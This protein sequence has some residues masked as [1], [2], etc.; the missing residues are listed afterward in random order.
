LTES[1]ELR[2]AAR[3]SKPQFR[4]G[5]VTIRWDFHTDINTPARRGEGGQGGKQ[6]DER[7]P[8]QVVSSQEW[9]KC[10]EDFVRLFGEIKSTRIPKAKLP[11]HNEALNA[12]TVAVIDDGVT[13][14]HHESAG[15]VFSGKS[16]SVYDDGWRVRPYWSSDTG[17]GTLMARLIHRVCPK[18]HIDVIKLQ[19]RV[20]GGEGGQDRKLQIV[21]K[22]AIRAV[23]EA[24]DR[25]A[26]IISMSWTIK[27]PMSK[28][29]E[30]MW[31]TTFS[32]AARKKVLLFCS[33]TDRGKVDDVS[34]PHSCRP[35]DTFRI[36]AATESR[37]MWEMVSGK[38][39]V[40]FAL[41]GKD[42]LLSGD[43]TVSPST[44]S[45]SLGDGANNTHPF[46]AHTGSSVSTALA[47]GLAALI[48]ECVR[49]GRIETVAQDA[50]NGNVVA[51]VAADN[52]ILRSDLDVIRTKK[53]MEKAFRSIGTSHQTEDKFINVE[54]LFAEVTRAFIEE[55]GEAERKACVTSLARHFLGKGSFHSTYMTHK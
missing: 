5:P 4:R 19:T 18:A 23:K 10:L 17:H 52:T 26:D 11:S 14:P 48:L 50:G 1:I 13:I 27:K 24:I 7:P 37:G 54:E 45:G 31:E 40:D 3:A 41:P 25:G 16:F 46:E 35:A 2:D 55:P 8:K 53:G 38:D 12:T 9:I 29:D 49:I 21:E 6:S 43:E 42:V 51:G 32:E 39:K 30:R 33:A 20:T 36:G 15:K 34:Y 47:A 28:E 22:D 44:E